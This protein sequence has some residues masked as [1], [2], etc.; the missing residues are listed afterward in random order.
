MK[1]V[2]RKLLKV[3]DFLLTVLQILD[4]PI[5]KLNQTS[6]ALFMLWK[7]KQ[8]DKKLTDKVRRQGKKLPNV[9]KCIE[10]VVPLLIPL[11]YI[12]DVLRVYYKIRNQGKHIF[13]GT[14]S[15]LTLY[16]PGN[17]HL[18]MTVTPVRLAQIIDRKLSLDQ[19]LECIIFEDVNLSDEYK[20]KTLEVMNRAEVVIFLSCSVGRVGEFKVLPIDVDQKDR[21][22]AR[23]FMID[24]ATNTGILPDEEF[25]ILFGI[26]S[27]SILLM[28]MLVSL[29][30]SL[31]GA[32]I[33]PYVAFAV[34][35]GYIY[36]GIILQ[37]L[38]YKL[39]QK[40]IELTKNSLI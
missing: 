28:L 20:T 27:T 24:L 8:V 31:K 14:K 33:N 36:S 30:L 1:G 7:C 38:R 18:I 25:R 21:S 19:A 9:Q 5:I 16:F 35:V 26:R 15:E 40:L 12:F 4:W 39:S 22:W 23:N 32:V 10:V 17:K 2:Y 6:S 29:A 37:Q 13:C 3:I 34:C 11:Q